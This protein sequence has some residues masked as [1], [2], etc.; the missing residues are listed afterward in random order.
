METFFFKRI[1]LFSVNNVHRAKAEN[2]L[3]IYKKFI[4]DTLFLAPSS[5]RCFIYLFYVT[6]KE[7]IT[8]TSKVVALRLLFVGFSSF[9][10]AIKLCQ[11]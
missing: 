2:T 7:G 8:W 10:K 9:F 6:T 5:C 3:F 11:Y 1:N 4:A